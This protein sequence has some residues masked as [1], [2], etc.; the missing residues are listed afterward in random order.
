MMTIKEP[1]GRRV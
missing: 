1:F